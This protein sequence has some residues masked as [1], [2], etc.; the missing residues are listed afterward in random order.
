MNKESWITIRLNGDMNTKKILEL[1]DNSYKL[2]LAKSKRG[3]A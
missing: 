3:T 2:S 1:I